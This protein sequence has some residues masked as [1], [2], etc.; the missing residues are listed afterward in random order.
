M[1]VSVCGV[2][3]LVRPIASPL[4]L[5]LTRRNLPDTEVWRL[6]PTRY[7]VAYRTGE[8]T[9]RPLNVSGLPEWLGLFCGD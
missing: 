4:A 9:K 3:N 2:S 8:I 5:V 7:S 1:G 6:N